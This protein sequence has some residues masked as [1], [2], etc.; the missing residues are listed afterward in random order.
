M[1]LIHEDENVI[2][3]ALDNPLLRWITAVIGRLNQDDWHRE[4]ISPP[5][6]DWHY[7]MKL[8]PMRLTDS[9]VSDGLSRVTREMSEK[10]WLYGTPEQVGAQL[11]GFVDVGASWIHIADTLP[12]VLDPQDAA[13]SPGRVIETARVVKS[14]SPP[15]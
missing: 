1:C 8:L 6:P 3:R 7:A 11:T 14:S 2:D 10:T 13:Q 9:D 5:M 15:S 4:G 12:L